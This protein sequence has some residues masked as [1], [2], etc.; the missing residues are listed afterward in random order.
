VFYLCFQNE[1]RE[2]FWMQNIDDAKDAE[3]AAAVNAAIN[4]KAAHHRW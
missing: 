1:R 3:N 2:F 4:G